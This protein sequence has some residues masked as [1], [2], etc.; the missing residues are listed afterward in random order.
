MHVRIVQS[1]DVNLLSSR[2][3]LE[4]WNR[5]QAACLCIGIGHIYVVVGEDSPGQTLMLKLGQLVITI[6]PAL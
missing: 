2:F 5:M 6:I 3:V 4:L 1:G